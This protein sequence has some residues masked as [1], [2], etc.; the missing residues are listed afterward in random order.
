ML[1]PVSPLSSATRLAPDRR[2]VLAAAADRVV[3]PGQALQLAA[4]WGV[5][6]VWYQGSHLSI[7]RESQTLATVEQAVVAAGWRLPLR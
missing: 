7:R 6:P 4:H 1:G 3:P 2:F 5:E